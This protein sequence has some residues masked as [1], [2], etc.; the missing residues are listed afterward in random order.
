M[1]H[2]GQSAGCQKPRS[3]RKRS[4]VSEEGEDFFGIKEG[5]RGGHGCGEAT[6]S[7]K[8]LEEGSPGRTA[9]AGCEGKNP[10]DAQKQAGKR[11]LDWCRDTTW[12]ATQL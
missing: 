7:K 5:G 3:K 6:G 2:G 12:K 10:Q 11:E 1:A 9:L 8:V 4:I